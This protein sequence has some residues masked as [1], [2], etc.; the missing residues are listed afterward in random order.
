MG[1]ISKNLHIFS[2]CHKT[3]L[4]SSIFFKKWLKCH[5]IGQYERIGTTFSR[6]FCH[7]IVI[8]FL[9][10]WYVSVCCILAGDQL[11]QLWS[12]ILNS[13]RRSLG[14][15]RGGCSTGG[16]TVT[17]IYKQAWDQY[18]GIA[19][20]WGLNQADQ[21]TE[22]CQDIPIQRNTRKT[23]TSFPNRTPVLQI[24]KCFVN[25]ILVLW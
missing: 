24:Q 1:N 5:S 9:I 23:Y 4:T 8:V 12:G 6:L 20:S 7:T 25:N 13:T 16:Y 18:F 19:K 14:S 15:N 2:F 22:T 11:K 21:H 17:V 10:D 3:T